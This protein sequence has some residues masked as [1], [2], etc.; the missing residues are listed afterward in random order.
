MFSSF[1]FPGKQDKWVEIDPQ[2]NSSGLNL[3]TNTYISQENHFPK[4][5]PSIYVG[6]FP[7]QILLGNCHGKEDILKVGQAVEAQTN[8]R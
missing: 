5:R 4:I 8:D 6:K 1:H 7:E 3:L 2:N